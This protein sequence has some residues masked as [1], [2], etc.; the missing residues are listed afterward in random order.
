MILATTGDTY[1]IMQSIYRTSEAQQSHTRVSSESV[2]FVPNVFNGQVINLI[3]FLHFFMT[4]EI[5]DKKRL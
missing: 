1:N 5:F 2:P 4:K 3:P